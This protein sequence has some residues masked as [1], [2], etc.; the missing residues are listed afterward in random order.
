LEYLGGPL[1]SQFTYFVEWG[2]SLD[3]RYPIDIPFGHGGDG[4]L[5][6]EIVYILNNIM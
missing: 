1:D 5:C 2:D 6:N 3:I 4:V